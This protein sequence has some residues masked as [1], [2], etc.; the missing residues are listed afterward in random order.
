METNYDY[1]KMLDK[2]MCSLFENTT[3][4]LFQK[5]VIN[6]M[7]YSLNAGGKRVRATLVYEFCK[8]CN[9]D[10]NKAS[11]AACAIEMIHT[12][13]LIHDDLPSMDNDDFRRGKPSC[14]K[15][16][17][18]YTAILAGDALNTFAFQILADDKDISDTIKVKLI[19]ELSKAAGFL[20]MIGGQQMDLE[21]ENTD[22]VSIEELSVMC[23]AK[24]GALIQCACRLG[25]ITAH[26]PQYLVDKASEYGMYIGLAFQIVDDL[27]DVESTTDVLGKPVNSDIEENKSTFVTIL[28]IQ[29]SKKKAR[30]YTEKALSILDVFPDN[31][32]MKEYTKEL[33]NR[34]N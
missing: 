34:I 10:I 22:N 19:S 18:E 20:G 27:L 12:Y 11:V 5:R 9:G 4:D 3:D 33:L 26:A 29:E 8:M 23:L 13:S 16:F 2:K 1:I 32:F 7:E 30:Y 31:E 6:A 15:A 21:L 25:A 24:T 17:D 28:G 14:H